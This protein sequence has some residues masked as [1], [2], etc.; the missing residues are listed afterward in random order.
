MCQICVMMLHFETN[1][2]VLFL[3]WVDNV[4]VIVEDKKAL[5]TEK[6]VMDIG[7]K[8]TFHCTLKNETTLIRW[9]HS[10][11]QDLH[12]ESGGRIQ[13]FRNGTFTIESVELSDGG[14][15][16][17]KGLK[18]IRYYT[19]YVHGMSNYFKRS[20]VFIVYFHT[21]IKYKSTVCLHPQ[22]AKANR[23]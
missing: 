9:Y 16:T 15:Y 4:F 7:A 3:I 18:Y 11:G 23:G 2:K 13:T 10:T 14:T 20:A 1:L 6:L 12:S 17:C 19:I 21:T 22:L 8:D 5:G